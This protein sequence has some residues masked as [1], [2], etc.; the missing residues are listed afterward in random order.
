MW[1]CDV[2]QFCFA[3]NVIITDGDSPYN[4]RHKAGHGVG[5]LHPFGCRVVFMPLPSKLKK[6]PKSAPRG[7]T[8]VFLGVPREAWWDVEERVLVRRPL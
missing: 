3:H 8:C 4:R 6:E 1:P 2:Q 7:I 5:P